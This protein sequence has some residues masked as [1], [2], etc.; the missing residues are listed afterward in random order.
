[1]SKHHNEPEA[2]WNLSELIQMDLSAEKLVDSICTASN[3]F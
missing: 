2:L 3:L 1:M